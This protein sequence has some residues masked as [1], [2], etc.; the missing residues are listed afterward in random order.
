M[1]LFNKELSVIKTTC[2]PQKNPE[3]QETLLIEK[4]Q[5]CLPR[6]FARDTPPAAKQ[7]GLLDLLS[8]NYKD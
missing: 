1:V 2:L 8:F 3:T 7:Q 6:S 4:M 5:A